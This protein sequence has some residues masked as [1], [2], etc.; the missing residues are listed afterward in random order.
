MRAKK[1]DPPRA[2]AGTSKESAEARVAM[3]VEAYLVNG[4]NG[5]EAAKAAG[6][7]PKSAAQQA[8]RLLT[9]AKV[10]ARI[11]ARRGSLIKKFE[12]TTERVMRNLAQVLYFDPRKLYREDG[13]LKPIHE[14]DDDTAQAISGFEVLEDFQGR[15]EER[16]LSSLTKKVKWLDKNTAR[17]QAMK[18]LGE[19]EADN[20][21]RNPIRE[22]N[23]DALERF[24]QR[25]AKEAGVS[26][27]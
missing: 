6:Y 7:S 1:I 10:Q 5:S 14:L 9:D 16:E 11:S 8:S 18:H 23:D 20:R 4:E 3:F 27:H 24:V 13:S 12:L 2:K 21:Q 19:Y 26:L 25:K 22:M 15:G 17:D